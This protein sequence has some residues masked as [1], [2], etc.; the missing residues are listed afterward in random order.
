M[1]KQFV[2]RS[3]LCCLLVVFCAN[4]VLAQYGSD[5]IGRSI[6]RITDWATKVLGAGLVV[7]GAI[8]VGIKMSMGDPEA[9]KKGALVIVGGLIIFLSKNILALIKGFAGQ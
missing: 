9:L 8:L 2:L 1:S 6:D 7:I 4:F 3:L 5:T